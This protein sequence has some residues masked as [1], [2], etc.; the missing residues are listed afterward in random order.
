MLFTAGKLSAEVSGTCWKTAKAKGEGH[1]RTLLVGEE[2]MK[3]G[4]ARVLQERG[5]G[6]VQGTCL[7]GGLRSPLRIQLQTHITQ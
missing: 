7:D 2:L 3:S 1:L 6:K 4:G 5:P